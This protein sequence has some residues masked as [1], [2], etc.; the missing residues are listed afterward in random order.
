[1]RNPTREHRTGARHA[2]SE[3]RRRTIRKWQMHKSALATEYQ[4]GRLRRSVVTEPS[5]EKRNL[6]CASLC[7]Q[8]TWMIEQ[9]EMTSGDRMPLLS[10][11]ERLKHGTGDGRVGACH[12]VF[13]RDDHQHRHIDVPTAEPRLPGYRKI[14]DRDGDVVDPQAA[15]APTV[16]DKPAKG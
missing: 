6:C 11:S 7:E 12:L 9:S 2:R 13:R 8:L 5:I 14:A 10:T 1:M 4:T 3:S 16:F 15:Q